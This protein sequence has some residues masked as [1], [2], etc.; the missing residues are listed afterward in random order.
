M[1]TKIDQ[2]A[3]ECGAFR[4]VYDQ[5]LIKVNENFD[6]QKF[7]ELIIN[8]CVKELDMQLTCHRLNSNYP[9]SEKDYEIGTLEEAQK[10]S[11]NRK[12]DLGK[13][14]VTYSTSE[15]KFTNP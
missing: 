14:P 8:D 1:N 7:A 5:K 6:Y 12:A 11:D 9:M 10:F 3:L 4:Q 15:K 13:F 2:I